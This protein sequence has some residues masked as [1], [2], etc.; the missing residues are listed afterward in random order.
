LQAVERVT[1][2]HIADCASEDP[3]PQ[4][5]VLSDD[6]RARAARII[7]EPVR[8]TFIAARS[9]LRCILARKLGQGPEA[10]EFDYQRWGKPRL[11]GNTTIHFSVTHS[12]PTAAIAIG[13]SP[14]GLD[15]E[16]LIPVSP[17]VV[18]N[19][20]TTEERARVAAASDPLAS[21]HAH[22]T[23]KEAYLKALGSG[24]N[25]PLESLTVVPGDVGRIG[26]LSFKNLHVLDGCMAA[27]AVESPIGAPFPE[28]DVEAWRPSV[29][30]LAGAH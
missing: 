30:L 5:A 10:V 9:A 15:L 23:L 28:V 13:A 20:L 2:W 3:Q 12:G 19:A 22:W 26:N 25:V 8:R 7:S 14:L 27:L 4:L 6:E 21:F 18:E 16:R 11:S 1:I 17:D 29:G 24:L